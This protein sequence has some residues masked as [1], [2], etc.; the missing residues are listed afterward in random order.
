M[1]YAT[2]IY[3]ACPHPAER[4]WPVEP[5]S[6]P[7]GASVGAAVWTPPW[8]AVSAG[9]AAPDASPAAVLPAAEAGSPAAESGAGP[10]VAGVPPAEAEGGPAA[11]TADAPAPAAGE[12]AP[13]AD[14]PAPVVDES[15]VADASDQALQAEPSDYPAPD[16]HSIGPVAPPVESAVRSAQAAIHPGWDDSAVLPADSAAPPAAAD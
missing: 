12:Q 7:A 6:P 16:G 5:V 13:V 11:D 9:E 15:V 3:E 8:A 4:V 10:A 1:G 14:V 2:S